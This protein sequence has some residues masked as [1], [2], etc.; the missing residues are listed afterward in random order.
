LIIIIIRI[1]HDDLINNDA[2][3]DIQNK[4]N[5]NMQLYY[6]GYIYGITMINE[7]IKITVINFFEKKKK[8][9]HWFIKRFGNF[10]KY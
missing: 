7:D 9:K 8:D 4:C 3:K 10:I 2:V 6:N 5:I 1:D